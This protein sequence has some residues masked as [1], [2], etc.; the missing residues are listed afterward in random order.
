[1]HESVSPQ[2]QKSSRAYF[3]QRHPG[4]R[5]PSLQPSQPC[6][7]QR[8]TWPPWVSRLSVTVHP[9]VPAAPAVCSTLHPLPPQKLGLALQNSAQTSASQESLQGP[10]LLLA[11]STA[12]TSLWFSQSVQS[13]S[14]VWLCDPM[15]HSTPGL[16]V[17]H[18][19]PEST[20]TH[21]HRVGDAIQPSHPLLSPSPAFSLSQH[22]GL[23]QRVSSYQVAR[24]LEFQLQHQSFQ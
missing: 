19:L 9:G 20:Q 21:V 22:Q 4:I 14:R 17:H 7:S 12:V 23:F 15:D 2:S 24:V 6:L 5:R 1:M 3:H 11:L 10:S 8:L 13:L 18:Q 16:P